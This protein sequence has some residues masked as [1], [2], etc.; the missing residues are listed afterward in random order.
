M[1]VDPNPNQTDNEVLSFESIPE[2]Q[3]QEYFDLPKIVYDGPESLDGQM[4]N[5][6]IA[7]VP[8]DWSPP[9]VK[10]QNPFPGLF[11]SGFYQTDEILLPF[12]NFLY[13][14]EI[15]A[16]N[17]ERFFNDEK[18]IL[19]PNST[20]AINFIRE[21]SLVRTPYIRGIRHALE[22]LLPRE[23][24]VSSGFISDL[25]QEVSLDDKKR[26]R[27][28]LSGFKHMGGI[29]RWKTNPSIKYLKGNILY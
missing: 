2:E 20:D 28:F 14:G 7:H 4:V 12:I 26:A 13:L 22:L 5:T 25:S 1:L 19:F 9:Q 24:L 10:I 16:R 17:E 23:S 15:G 11:D 29:V 18:A 8:E 3:F 21:Y 6:L 27:L